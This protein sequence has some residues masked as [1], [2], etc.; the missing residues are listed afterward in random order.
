MKKLTFTKGEQTVFVT[1]SEWNELRSP[2]QRFQTQTESVK[3][4]LIT[5]IPPWETV[6]S[7]CLSF[8]FLKVY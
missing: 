3:S 8:C 6:A 5:D 7:Y 2:G 4:K 1:L